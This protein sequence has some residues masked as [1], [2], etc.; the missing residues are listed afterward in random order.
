MHSRYAR[1]KSCLSRAIELQVL[2]CRLLLSAFYDYDVL[3]STGTV[4]TAG[5][6]ISS[7]K[8]E[9]SINDDGR[10]AFIANVTGNGNGNAIITADGH[11]TPVKITFANPSTA[12][13]YDLAQITNDNL[14]VSKDAISGTDL[15]RTWNALSPGSNTVIVRDGD[16]SPPLNLA[17]DIVQLPTRANDGNTG[18][19]GIVGPSTGAYVKGSV[20]SSLASVS[21][22]GYR[23]MIGNGGVVALRTGVAGSQSIVVTAPTF[24]KIL[25]ATLGDF[26][27]V[28]QPGISDDGQVVAFAGNSTSLGK[29]IFLSYFSGANFTDPIKV[30]GMSSELGFDDA[31]NAVFLKDFDF[32]A[33]GSGTLSDR[34]GVVHRPA[35]AAGIADDTIL[36]SFI[37]TPSAAGRTNTHTAT[38]LLFNANKGIWTLKLTPSAPLHMVGTPAGAVEFD[39][40]TSPMPV[41]QVGDTIGGRIVT[42]FFVFDSVATPARDRTG[43]VRATID[44]GDN[45]VVFRATTATGDMVVR[46]AQLD[47]DSDGLYDHWERAGGGIDINRDGVTDLDINAMGANPMHKDLFLELDWLRPDFDTRRNFSPQAAAL[48]AFSNQFANAPLTNPDGLMGV[49]V[50]IDAGASLSQNMGAGSL[51][52]GDQ[53]AHSPDN[54]HINVVYYGNTD[55]LLAVP[56]NVD[57]YNRPLVSR[58]FEDIKKSF[59]STTDKGSREVAFKY[60]L[61]ADHYDVA[62]DMAGNFTGLD[63]SSGLAEA[64]EFAKPVV[65]QYVPGNDLIVSLQGGRGPRSGRLVVPTPVAGAPATVPMPVGFYQAQTLAHELGHT[66]GLRHGGFDGRTSSPPGY[67]G[68]NAA[69]YR[70]T[71][72]SLM[73]YAFQLDPDTS[74]N[75]VQDYS[76]AGDPN[77]DDWSTITFSFNQYFETTGGTPAYFS[78]GD[79]VPDEDS[80][81]AHDDYTMLDVAAVQGPLDS[82]APTL[83]IN[84][85]AQNANTCLGSPLTINL[86]A[87]DDGGVTSLKVSFDANGDGTISQNE[88]VEATATGATTY[89]AVF[90]NVSGSVG[91]RTLTATATD[92]VGFATGQTVNL[93][94]TSGAAPPPK[95]TASTFTFETAPVRLTF[96]FDQ[97]VSAS[98]AASDFFIRKTDGTGQIIP[99]LLPYDAA[100][101]RITLTLP[102]IPAD[103]RYVVTLASTGIINPTGGQLDGDANGTPGPDFDFNFFVLTGDANHDGSVDFLDLAKLA[104]SYNIADGLRTYSTG[105]FNYDGN[106]DF[107]DLALLAQR[108]NT[109]LPTA[110]VGAAIAPTVPVPT[111]TATPSFAAA[112]FLPS[113]VRDF[114]SG[115]S[116]KRVG[117]A[118]PKPPVLPPPARARV[119][120]AAR[121]S[122][123]VHAPLLT[124]VK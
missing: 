69:G 24:S 32:S 31:G 19:I 84:S 1:R 75:L 113:P 44:N 18:F 89:Q 36:L 79:I 99:T 6:T 106:T 64:G 96:T 13:T 100:N 124:Q 85:P 94:V 59:F 17:Y 42:D 39:R 80:A 107:L 76:R 82:S 93:N 28:S 38:P 108:Y 40:R 103:G 68:F 12:R 20:N 61:F 73:N 58:S 110:P 22:G 34:V 119:A 95:V 70:P 46:A 55:P 112:A 120:T 53:I 71:Y 123:D 30:A 65:N 109:A 2:E 47:T 50:H 86:T 121:R 115:F 9:T 105:D 87:T 14:V 33:A 37:A 51:Q 3:A 88:I 41:V 35:G 7:F 72:R 10:A 8:G 21:G 62:T 97:D 122:A 56:G 15:I 45:Y 52:G 102:G 98:L 92:G 81:Q 57:E 91:Q 90:A 4:T 25:T 78:R 48:T 43:A 118:R 5:D 29:G 83:A 116:R 77:F 60:V 54:K 66:L 16:P 74:G 101:N 23:P 49:N 26:T 114:V 111:T 11:S 63:F 104:Q 27:A 67:V 117:V